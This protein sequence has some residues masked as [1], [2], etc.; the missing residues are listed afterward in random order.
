MKAPHIYKTLPTT[1]GHCEFWCC[2]KISHDSK[3]LLILTSTRMWGHWVN[4]FACVWSERE[5]ERVVVC[6]LWKCVRMRPFIFLT[7]KIYT[8]ILFD[9]IRVVALLGYRDD[10]N[11]LGSFCSDD[12]EAFSLRASTVETV[13][14][15]DDS[16]RYTRASRVLDLVPIRP[17]CSLSIMAILIS[18]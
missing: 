17:V 3:V 11:R 6:V 12:R 4:V 9:L 7:K 16:I 13:V 8:M 1:R 5:S 15:N 14:R 10:S 18:Q 2:W